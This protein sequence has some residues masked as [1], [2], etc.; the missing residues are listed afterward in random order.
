MFF[1]IPGTET[2]VTPDSD[3]P[4]IPNDT[5]YHGDWRLPRKNASLSEWLRAVIRDM[6]SNIPKYPEIDYYGDK[7]KYSVHVI[8]KLKHKDNQIFCIFVA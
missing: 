5:I 4:I 7:D 3:A 8:S 6:H 1:T 2:N